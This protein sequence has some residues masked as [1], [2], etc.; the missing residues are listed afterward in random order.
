MNYLNSVSYTH[1]KA[2]VNFNKAKEY[3]LEKLNS[4]RNVVYEQFKNY[5][6]NE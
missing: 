4:R 6:I 2:K 3:E 5:I 1:L